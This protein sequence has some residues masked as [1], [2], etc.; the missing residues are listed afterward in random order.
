MKKVSLR[1]R[2]SGITLDIKTITEV[3][4]RYGTPLFLLDFDIVERN[5]GRLRQAFPDALIAYSYKTNFHP[6]LLKFLSE[7]G[8][9]SEVTSEMEIYFAQQVGVPPSKL[10][11]NGP[12]K[13]LHEL[14]LATNLGVFCLIANS[15]DELNLV[16]VV[17]KRLKRMVNVGIRLNPIWVK[18]QRNNLW[19]NHKFGVINFR[20]AVTIIESSRW[21]RPILVHAHLGTAIHDEKIYCSLVAGLEKFAGSFFPYI[22]IGGGFAS[23]ETLKKHNKSLSVIGKAILS[24]KREVHKLI[25]E[26]GRYLIE[27]AGFVVARVLNVQE[28]GWVVLDIGSNFLVPLKSA[29]YSVRLRK[30]G[31]SY[32][33]GGNLCFGADVIATR[34]RAASPSI[35]EL[36]VVGN[37]GAYTLS[38]S[39]QFSHPRP[40][41]VIKHNGQF[42]LATRA[43]TP[44]IVF[45]HW[46]RK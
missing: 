12:G 28:N 15:I 21:L 31:G 6:A 24:C 44:A 27:N 32:N 29:S 39:S 18:G 45:E 23:E 4:R 36:A 38:M 37:A 43:E 13:S 17:A 9:Y 1:T 35:G 7:Q 22:D 46:A 11:F 19:Q 34:V 33:I 3:A 40:K 41:V 20:K 5:L 10:I 2:I 14:E 26:P 25:I 8:L 30:G 42:N 16:Q